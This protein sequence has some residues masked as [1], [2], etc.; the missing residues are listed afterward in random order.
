M[1]KRNVISRRWIFRESTSITRTFA[2][3]IPQ[4]YSWRANEWHIWTQQSLGFHLSP[5]SLQEKVFFEKSQ[6][7][8]YVFSHYVNEFD[9]TLKTFTIGSATVS[10]SLITS[11][12]HWCPTVSIMMHLYQSIS[13]SLRRSYP[14]SVTYSFAKKGKESPRAERT[15]LPID[16]W[17]DQ[18]TNKTEI[19]ALQIGRASCRE[20][21]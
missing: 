12:S 8:L 20:R 14:V 7:L 11:A 1:P 18:K 3:T 5:I 13:R 16:Q 9:W 19:I 10:I 2:F 6:I 15:D 21:V 4:Q 17:T